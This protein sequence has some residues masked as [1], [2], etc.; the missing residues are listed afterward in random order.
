MARLHLRAA[1]VITQ[2]ERCALRFE[3]RHRGRFCR[4]LCLALSRVKRLIPPVAAPICAI[5]IHP[6]L[7]ARRPS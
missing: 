2:P 6:M 1:L 3:S 7:H 5:A 4:P